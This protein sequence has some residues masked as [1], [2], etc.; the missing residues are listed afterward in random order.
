MFYPYGQ[1]FRATTELMHKWMMRLM[2]PP[3]TQDVPH[4]YEEKKRKMMQ[5]GTSLCWFSRQP[6]RP[7]EECQG[8]GVTKEKNILLSI[9]AFKAAWS[10]V[11]DCTSCVKF[12]LAG[13]YPHPWW[14]ML[15]GYLHYNRLCYDSYFNSTILNWARPLLM[16]ECCFREDVKKKKT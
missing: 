5:R 14:G 16:S 4:P 6:C 8:P 13:W 1:P 12:I 10:T 9:S 15:K 11:F 3:S 7:S 2:I